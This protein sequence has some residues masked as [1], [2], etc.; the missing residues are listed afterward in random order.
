LLSQIPDLREKGS[1][2]RWIE[3][4]EGLIQQEKPGLWCKN[5]GESRLA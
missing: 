5:A 4:G 1:L 2:R 3:A